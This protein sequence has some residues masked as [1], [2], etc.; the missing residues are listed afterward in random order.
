LEEVV[1]RVLW[2][3]DWPSPGV[4]EMWRNIEQFRSLPLPKPV[5]DKITSE[6]AMKVFPA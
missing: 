5:Q 6:N 3:T 4:H 2:G 1:D